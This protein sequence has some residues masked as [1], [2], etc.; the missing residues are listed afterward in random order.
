MLEEVRSQSWARG[1]CCAAA[2]VLGVVFSCHAAPPAIVLRVEP[3]APAKVISPVLCPAEQLAPNPLPGVEN[4]QRALEYWLARRPARELDEVLLDERDLA[5][6][7]ASLRSRRDA[8]EL[9]QADLLAPVPLDR[10]RG[11]VASRLGAMRAALAEQ[12]LVGDRGA[13]LDD[14][15]RTLLSHPGGLSQKAELRVAVAPVPLRCA[16]LRHGLFARVRTLDPRLDRNAC[17]TAQV[18]EPVQLLGAWPNGMRLGRTRYA[19]GWIAADAELSPGLPESLREPFTRGPKVTV[20]GNVLATSD[21]GEKVPAIDGARLPRL[22]AEAVAV[23]TRGRFV[24]ARLPEGAAV[25]S[26]RPLTRRALL[27]EAFRLVDQPYGWGDSNGG[28]DCSRLLMDVLATFGLE[29]P[30]VS[31]EQAQ[32]GSYFV[33]VPPGLDEKERLSLIDAASAEGV[34]LLH[35]PGHIM[36]YLG[37]DEAGVPMA[38]HSF[39]EYLAPCAPDASDQGRRSGETRERVDRVTVSTLDLGRGTSRRSFLERVTRIV[40]FGRTPG[41]SLEGAA[42]LRPAAPLR[43]PD[44]PSCEPAHN[45]GFLASPTVPHVGGTLR[46]LFASDRALGPVEMVVV[47]PDGREIRPNVHVLLGPAPSYMATFTPSERGRYRVALG[48]GSRVV[49]CERVDVAARPRRSGVREGAFWLPRRAWNNQSELL[50]AAFVERLFDYPQDESLSW[51]NLHTLLRDGEH[52]V[53]R[54]SLSAREDERLVLTP[55]CADLPYFLRAYFA[56]KQRL[57]FSFRKC[58]YGGDGR[59][60]ACEKPQSNFEKYERSTEV[61][62][63]QKF[64][65]DLVKNAVSALGGRTLPHE[66]A[67]DLYPVPLTRSALAPGTIFVD[68]YGHLLVVSKWVAQGASS[69]GLLVGAEAQP[70]GTIGRRRF[71]QG[72]FL[73]TPD[74]T[75]GA[76][77]FKRFRPVMYAWAKSG[78]SNRR[79]AQTP[80]FV[81]KS[82]EQYGISKDEFYVKMEALINPRG[83]E[84][85][86]VLLGL[87]DA[88]VEAATRRV[89]SV[90][91]GEAYFAAKPRAVIAM[92]TAPRLIFEAAGAWEDYS[93]PSRDLRLLIA[94]DT[95]VGFAEA[96]RRDPHRYRMEDRAAVAGVVANVEKR[97]PEELRKR[98][99]AYH[100]TDGSEFRLTLAEL[101]ERQAAF[102]VGYNP[103]DC[104]ERRWGADAGSV[105]LSTCRRRAPSDQRTRMERW[106]GF[107]RERQRPLGPHPRLPVGARP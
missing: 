43:V 36:L 55:D 54:D 88:L 42:T 78:A 53:L 46:L 60:P 4:K 26:P 76:A 9:G 10:L 14:A 95:V 24:R 83:R 52:N 86:S 29:L 72:S 59:R 20:R 84:P 58:I 44:A 87:V 22:D 67:S 12:R 25:V 82:D 37:R 15:V 61:E 3:P 30:R 75:N 99:I 31:G 68:P 64:A 8:D 77:G 105:E 89:K 41:N 102:E 13:P 19:L 107:F 98:S 65:G 6:L 74:T 90:D 40:V 81:P 34:A 85:L 1:C 62:A 17:S 7:Q 38:L 70:D 69:P 32:A 104:P 18:G 91:N 79:L 21:G 106:R 48:E 33:E 96:L 35:F 71:W 97:L 93:T 2:L 11:A 47:G 5:D 28:R 39:A 50:Y 45:V 103:N 100:R 80:D 49:S 23:P 27:T 101:V 73:F 56:W 94:I 66:D 57:P 92:P 63:F 51:P 16:P